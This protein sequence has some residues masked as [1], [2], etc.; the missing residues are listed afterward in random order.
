MLGS[1]A[2]VP[3][4]GIHAQGCVYTCSAN[5]SV[6]LPALRGCPGLALRRCCQA[7][8]VLLLGKPP[9]LPWGLRTASRSC[10]LDPR[11]CSRDDN[12]KSSWRSRYARIDLP[13]NPTSQGWFTF[14]GCGRTVTP[15]QPPAARRQDHG[16]RAS[17]LISVIA[18]ARC[19]RYLVQ[20]SPRLHGCTPELQDLPDIHGRYPRIPT[21]M[22]TSGLDQTSIDRRGTLTIEKHCTGLFSIRNTAFTIR[23]LAQYAATTFSLEE[24]MY[25][26]KT[27]TICTQ[28][29]SQHH[30][31]G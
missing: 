27:D 25:T 5:R 21:R 24:G 2:C 13:A 17:P 26:P 8:P 11:S 15:R 7:R 14:I 19:C 23:P 9:V 4:T 12:H 31:K 20:H 3:R 30:P 18:P 28:S 16:S 10:D 22:L 6:D 29:D 1:A